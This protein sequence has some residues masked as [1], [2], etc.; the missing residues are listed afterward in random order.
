MIWLNTILTHTELQCMSQVTNFK[1]FL[2]AYQ[3]STNCTPILEP[4]AGKVSKLLSMFSYTET[5]P[6]T[7]VI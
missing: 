2:T 7:L 1:N 5:L 3:N 6:V 4:R